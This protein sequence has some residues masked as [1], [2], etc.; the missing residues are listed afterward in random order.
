[1]NIE[2]TESLLN[3]LTEKA[4]ALFLEFVNE[5]CPT[6]GVDSTLISLQ[7]LKKI[8][9]LKQ[10]YGKVVPPNLK[11]AVQG[12]I[13]ARVFAD[14]GQP[15]ISEAILKGIKEDQTSFSSILDSFGDYLSE[16]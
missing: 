12:E 10:E 4:D 3:E 6:L 2:K 8:S 7:Y 9:S 13:M 15:L 5:A 14:S 11:I 16:E 1:M